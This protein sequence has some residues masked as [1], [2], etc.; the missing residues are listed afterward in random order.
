MQYPN[1]IT[2]FLPAAKIDVNNAIIDELAN[3]IHCDHLY[4]ARIFIH[5]DGRIRYSLG[6]CRD[7]IIQAV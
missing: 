4:L 2:S 6:P 3:K 7:A 1:R 5:G